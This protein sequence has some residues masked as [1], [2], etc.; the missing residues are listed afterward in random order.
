MTL[1]EDYD[2][3]AEELRR[4]DHDRYL[5]LLLAEEPLRQSLLAL[6]A[7]NLEVARTAES[8]SEPMIGQIRLQWWR[9][10]LEGIYAGE[11]RRHAVIQPLAK[12]VRAGSLTRKHFETLIDAR[13]RDLDPEP[14]ESLKALEDY[15][16]ATTLPLIQLALEAAGVREGPAVKAARHAALAQ[17]LTGI[18]RATAFLASQRRILLPTKA[19]RAAEVEPQDLIEGRLKPM[20]LSPVVRPIAQRAGRHL[21]LARRDAKGMERRLLPVFLPVTLAEHYLKRLH[22]A[23][24]DPLDPKVSGDSAARPF[25]LLGAKL[26]KRF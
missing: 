21:D 13:E 25:R 19:L 23:A 5:T 12:A 24:F 8:V 15:A 20:A 9:D 14:P 16:E 10:S 6:Y 7:F 2:Y 3:C 26:L 11:P 1:A 22:G 4:F 17:G 18:L